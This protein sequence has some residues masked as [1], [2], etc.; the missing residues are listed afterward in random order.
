MPGLYLNKNVNF[1]DVAFFYD[2]A[3][4]ILSVGLTMS[5]RSKSLSWLPSTQNRRRLTLT[6]SIALRRSQ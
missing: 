1:E 6:N 3:N 5:I 2:S 4:G